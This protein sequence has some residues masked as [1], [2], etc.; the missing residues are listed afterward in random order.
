MSPLIKQHYKPKPIDRVG[1]LQIPKYVLK[2]LHIQEGDTFILEFD[3][4]SKVITFKPQQKGVEQ[5]NEF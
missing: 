1:R 3:P 4:E 5:A 2:L